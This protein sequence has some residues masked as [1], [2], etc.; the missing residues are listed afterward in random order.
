MSGTESPADLLA[1]HLD[2]VYRAALHVARRNGCSPEEA[3]EFRG[4][5]LEFLTANDYA[6]IRRFRGESSLAT[7]LTVVVAGQMR[8]FRAARQGR[9]RPSAEA[10]RIGP[11]APR[12]EL[13]VLRQGLTLAQAAEQLRQRGETALSDRELALILDRLPARGPMRPTATGLE[14]VEG[15]ASGP[16]PLE[17][18][19]RAETDARVRGALQAALSALPAEDQ[20]VLRMHYWEGATLQTV[21]RALH[22][23]PKPLYKRVERLRT[24]LR[25]RLEAA[26]VDRSDV[27]AG[28]GDG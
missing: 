27:F 18:L 26:G 16:D 6:A 12:L 11:P 19:E 1:G 5:V 20:V 7:Y 9:W 2:R 15:R 13:L 17:T 14:A 23:E 10:K 3:E 24:T 22:L 25:R 4:W 21:A 28:R 8:D